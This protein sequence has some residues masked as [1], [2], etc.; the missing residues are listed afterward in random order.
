[1]SEALKSTGPAIQG[2]SPAADPVRDWEAVRAAADIQYT[3]LPPLRPPT[4]PQVPEWLQ[5][6]GEWL[7][8]LL[9]PLGRLLGVSWPAM[10]YVLIA[11]ALLG[12]LFLLWRLVLQPL[13]E[14]ARK[15][16][17][18]SEPE[19]SP[20][21]GQA[22]ALL[23]EADRLAAQGRFGEAVRLLLHRSVQHLA[24]AQPTWLLPATT[25]REIAGLPRLPQAAR[26]AFG[27]IAQH[28]ERS[29]FALRDLE[30]S[31]WE[32]ARA[33]YADFALQDFARPGATT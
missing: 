30:R 13:I 24:D 14:R 31:D 29:L 16:Q 8:A 18:R 6:L 23:A 10:Q 15:P 33:A 26:Q 17:P 32:A 22:V 7:R 27:T 3:P 1:V 5:V 20:E 11:L 25:A 2:S 12:G 9:E 19:W 28:V 21:R 4:P